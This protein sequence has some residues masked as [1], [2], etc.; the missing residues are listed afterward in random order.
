MKNHFFIFIFS[1]LIILSTISCKKK[2]TCT[3]KNQCTTVQL[4]SVE[5]ISG[6]NDT[7]KQVGN[8]YCR[9]NYNSDTDYNTD[10]TTNQS[11]LKAV[12]NVSSAS[13]GI[14]IVSQYFN[15]L[16]IAQPDDV[17]ITKGSNNKSSYESKGFNCVAQ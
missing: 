4:F 9:I 2:Y 17:Q 6:K 3:L 1:L 14:V 16:I 8:T 11:N 10:I 12:T 5:I 7:I 13:Q 15:N